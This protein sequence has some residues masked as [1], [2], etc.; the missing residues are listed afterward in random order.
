MDIDE[1]YADV[2]SITAMGVH[3][4]F[5]GSGDTRSETHVT[6]SVLKLSGDEIRVKV[7]NTGK[8]LFVEDL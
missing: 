5:T 3:L 2:L 4:G 1:K 8:F 7:D 6:G